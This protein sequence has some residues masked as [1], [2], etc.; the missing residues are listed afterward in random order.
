M[1]VD[2]CQYAFKETRVSLEASSST[3]IVN[4]RVPPPNSRTSHRR[5]NAD[6]KDTDEENVFALKNLASSSTIFR[7]RVHASPRSF[8]WRVLEDGLVLSV[9]AVDVF[10]Q[11]VSP[12]APYILNFH[13][14]S[15]I[16]QSCVALAEPENN[17]ALCIFVIDQAGNLYS[18]TLRTDNFRRRASDSSV[19]DGCSVFSSQSLSNGQPLRLV[20]ASA[21][22]ILVTLRDGGLV[23]LDRNTTGDCKASFFTESPSAC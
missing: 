6:G 2:N 16:Q 22:R 15:S 8:L 4:I 12:E 5:H 20:V 10:R 17:D 21:D 3:F 9:R 7:R 23:R 14:P 1:D 18:F 11:D 13:F 19:K